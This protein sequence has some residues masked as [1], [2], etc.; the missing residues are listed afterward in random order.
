MALSRMGCCQSRSVASVHSHHIRRRYLGIFVRNVRVQ[1]NFLVHGPRYRHRAGRRS[2]L[3]RFH[4]FLSLEFSSL[5]SYFLLAD[6]LCRCNW[7]PCSG[8]R[9]QISVSA[10]AVVSIT[11][12]GQGSARKYKEAA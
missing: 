7:R 11:R 12:D 8:R 5:S 3:W 9:N 4:S 2:L 6:V 10:I 1:Y